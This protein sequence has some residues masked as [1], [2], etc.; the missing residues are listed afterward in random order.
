MEI[1]LDSVWAICGGD[2]TKP[3]FPGTGDTCGR[4]S[5]RES[6]DERS[7]RGDERVVGGVGRN[8]DDTVWIYDLTGEF[9][10]SVTF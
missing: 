3:A 4:G 7:E 8:I 10:A 9:D 5:V 1:L 6:S 2:V